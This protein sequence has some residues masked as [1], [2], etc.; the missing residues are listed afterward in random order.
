MYLIGL[1]GKKGSGKDSAAD[2][3]C[4]EGW[5]RV[6]FADGLYTEVAEAFGVSVEFLSHR[7]GKESPSS[8]LT[9]S[10]CKNDTFYS[11]ALRILTEEQKYGNCKGGWLFNHLAGQFVLSPRKVLQLWGTEF[12]RAQSDTYWTDQVLARSSLA[13][14]QKIVV[15]DVRFENE[16]EA[17][18]RAGG[19]IL[20]VVR[21][22]NPYWTPGETHASEKLADTY[23]GDFTIVNDSTLESLHSKIKEYVK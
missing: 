7:D 8:Q 6:A 18:H 5:M 3:L 1:M 23:E 15:T 16:V 19:K 10:R 17:I 9:L 14:W 12:R 2:A 22:A 11:L 13:E 20:R 21:P 4:D